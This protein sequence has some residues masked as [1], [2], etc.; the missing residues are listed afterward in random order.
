ML[1]TGLRLNGNYLKSLAQPLHPLRNRY[2]PSA[3]V[4]SLR[5]AYQPVTGSSPTQQNGTE[6]IQQTIITVPGF[7]FYRQSSLLYKSHPIKHLNLISVL[8]N[9]GARTCAVV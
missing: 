7:E 5:K 8:T 4:T 2:I 1:S 9:I 3:T 6:N